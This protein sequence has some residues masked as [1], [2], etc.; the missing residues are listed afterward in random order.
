MLWGGVKRFCKFI[1]LAPILT[2]PTVTS[3]FAESFDHNLALTSSGDSRTYDG[4]SIFID[5]TGNIYE[6][7][8]EDK[9]Y[10]NKIYPN[11]AI[12][13]WNNNTLTVNGDLE[14]KVVP[15]QWAGSKIDQGT[16]QG[17]FIKSSGGTLNVSGNTKIFI[18]N[19]KHTDDYD[20][21]TESG[22]KEYDYG[23]NA[24]QGICVE[25]ENSSVK[26]D[27]NLDITMIDG[28]RS[29]GILAHDK[30]KLTVGGNTRIEVRNA[31]FYTYGISN[32]YSDQQYAFSNNDEDATMHFKGDLTIVTE[33]GNNSVGINLKD[34]KYG[35]MD[36]NFITVDGHL[37]ITSSGAT[38]YAGKTELQRFPNAVSNYG[39]FMYYVENSQFNTAD[40][41]TTS[42][43]KDV[44]S[45][46]TYMYWY[47]NSVFKGDVSYTTAADDRAVEIASLARAGSSIT[48]EK[49][50]KANADIVLNAVGNQSRDGSSITVN[51]TKDKNA[52]VQL[53]GNIVVGK[54]DTVMIWGEE[55]DTAVDAENT[56]NY[57]SVNLLNQ[58]SYFTGINEYGNQGSTINLNLAD[59]AKWNLTDSS[60]VS[61]LTINTNGT[62]DLT[63]N[64]KRAVSDYRTLTAET[65]NGNGGIFIVNTDIA[66]DKTDQIIINNGSGAHKVLVKP[67]GSEPDKEA[68]DSFIVQQKQ[69]SGT[70]SLANVGEKVE[71]GL[72]FYKLAN[73]TNDENAQEWYL[74]R[75]S[76]VP[77]DPDVP[78]IPETPTAQAVLGLSGMSS[79]YAMW[80]GQLSDL[81]ERLGEIRYHTSDDGLWVRAY[82]EESEL[83]GLAGLGFSQKYYGSAYGYDKLL[84]FDSSALL[85]GAKGQ[86]SHA[87]QTL[88]S[89]FSG[90]GNNDSYGFAAYATWMHDD[91]WYIDSILS[92]DHYDQTLRT[93]MLDGTSVRGDYEFYGMGA[94][95]E[96]GKTF[97]FDNNV[98][99]EPQVQLSYYFIE[100]KDFVTSN[101]MTAEQDNLDSLVGRL[102]MVLGKKWQLDDNSFIQPYFKA[103][104]NYEFL[105]DLDAV[106][107]DV[108]FSDDM[109]G[110]RAYYGVGL[111]YQAGD[112]VKIYGEFEREDG[113]NLTR[114]WSVSAGIRVMF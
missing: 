18:D 108:S 8:Y 46:G 65:V 45:I 97:R 91:G 77:I 82:G 84:Q 56:Q 37:D 107:N 47:S 64:D 23:M 41:K 66:A 111:D 90:S 34:S 25:G 76:L 85:I 15:A 24:Q 38:S 57:I 22:D 104:I 95:I 32:Q 26:F 54:T 55:Y 87:D 2:I 12:I 30:A 113:D 80:M 88:K 96:G 28:N 33:G 110:I 31:P 59:G 109:Q 114:P 112:S 79:A 67:S 10:E 70:Y 53:I 83:S 9:D 106:V 102:G 42:T 81:R 100:G 98:F 48:Y 75:D 94:S 17:L 19:Y 35:V 92:W 5:A 50:L 13:I 101:G 21:L 63:Y 93:N 71:H 27:G 69:G 20:W 14:S 39:I 60:P 4:L 61:T 89:N 58:N 105:G 52:L 11:S 73:R 40:I 62:V 74:L 68:M 72:Y 3:S 86:I 44:E 51:S 78:S 49:G 36:K 7:N 6:N 43:G 103:G 16:R 1:I 29:M 99:F